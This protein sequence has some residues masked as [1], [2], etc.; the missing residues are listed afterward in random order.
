MKHFLNL[1]WGNRLTQ[2]QMYMQFFTV[3][4]SQLVIRKYIKSLF[5]FL[6]AGSQ[7]GTIISYP[8]SGWLCAN[9]FAGGWP[10]VF[11]VFGNYIVYY[12]SQGST[13]SSSREL[14]L[15]HMTMVYFSEYH[16][17]GNHTLCFKTHLFCD[18]VTVFCHIILRYTGFLVVF[19]LDV[20]C[21]WYAQRTSNNIEGG[22][23]LYRVNC[24]RRA[25]PFATERTGTR[26]EHLLQRSVS[27]RQGSRGERSVF[28]PRAGALNSWRTGTINS[29]PYLKP[30]RTPPLHVTGLTNKHYFLTNTTFSARVLGFKTAQYEPD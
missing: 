19:C 2:R 30:N 3:K 11:Y 4:T 16:A 13:C 29:P 12:T 24:W 23:W 22:T 27:K 1:F 7:V 14:Q 17:M 6:Y 25:R 20:L 8:L 18:T 10:S 28:I 26:S 5:L 15:Y 21:V 9:G